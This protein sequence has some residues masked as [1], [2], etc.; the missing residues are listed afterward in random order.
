MCPPGF[1]CFHPPDMEQGNHLAVVS[2]CNLLIVID[3][4]LAEEC[5]VLVFKQARARAKLHST[6]II[7]FTVSW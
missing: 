6:F 2:T 4:Q 7:H 1:K 5:I 3:Q